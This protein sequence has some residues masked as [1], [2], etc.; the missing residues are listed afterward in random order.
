MK[1]KFVV[2]VAY[3]QFYYYVDVMSKFAYR[4]QKCIEN[5]KCC[6]KKIKYW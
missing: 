2:Q 6:Q 3:W 5:E 4:K 1:I